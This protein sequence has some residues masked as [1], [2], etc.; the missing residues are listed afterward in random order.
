MLQFYV[1]NFS[2]TS[3]QDDFLNLVREFNG[4]MKFPEMV[5]KCAVGINASNFTAA[6]S[7]PQLSTAFLALVR[8]GSIFKAYAICQFQI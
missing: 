8:Y 7:G 2:S 4:V 1:A 3:S 5:I 6:C